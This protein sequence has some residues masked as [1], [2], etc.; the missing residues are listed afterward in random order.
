ML[1]Q[2][3]NALL[4]CSV[5]VQWYQC[6]YQHNFHRLSGP[7][8]TGIFPHPESRLVEPVSFHVR[9]CVCVSVCLSAPL[10][11]G[12]SWVQRLSQL[13][14]KCL[15]WQNTILYYIQQT[16]ENCYY[17]CMISSKVAV[18]FMDWPD[19][20]QLWWLLRIVTIRVSFMASYYTIL[21]WVNKKSQ[22]REGLLLTRLSCLV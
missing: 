21:R 11:F 10:L 14:F 4:Q 16:Q 20:A 19:F 13:P 2:Y 22:H 7:Q 3:L 9:L 15:S 17:T 6:Y 5:S 8:Y 12:K 1:Q 18:I